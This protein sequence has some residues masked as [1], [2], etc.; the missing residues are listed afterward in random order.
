MLSS[1]TT[2]TLI[3]KRF[4]STLPGIESGVLQRTREVHGKNLPISG[5]LLREKAE[6]LGKN[7][8]YTDFKASSGWLDKFKNRNGIVQKAQ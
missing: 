7:F 8:G 1:K 2:S 6:E 3:K 5:I 4:K